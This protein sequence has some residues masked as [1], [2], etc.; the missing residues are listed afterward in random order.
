MTTSDEGRG[1]RAV[2][3]RAQSI[4]SYSDEDSSPDGGSFPTGCEWIGTGSPHVSRHLRW[5]SSR[6]SRTLGGGRRP[7]LS[8]GRSMVGSFGSFHGVLT[9]NWHACIVVGC[10]W[11]TLG[12]R[13]GGSGRRSDGLPLPGSATSHIGWPGDDFGGPRVWLPRQAALYARKKKWILSSRGVP[14]D[15]LENSQ[16]YESQ[17]QWNDSSVGELPNKVVDV[18]NDQSS[19]RQ[20]IKLS[21]GL[22]EHPGLRR[23]EARVT[24]API[25]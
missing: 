10:Q 16:G 20:L 5:P 9:P 2:I 18:Q 24:A 7:V 15:Y 1:G 17:W 25:H 4:G 8:C 22:P 3:G 12:V 6:I 14:L 21:E 19:R 13:V 23:L 11:F